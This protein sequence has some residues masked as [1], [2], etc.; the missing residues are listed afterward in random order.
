MDVNAFL[1]DVINSTN[2]TLSVVKI[3]LEFYDVLKTSSSLIKPRYYNMVEINRDVDKIVIGD[4][5]GDL[6][7][8]VS[9]LKRENLLKKLERNEAVLVFL[10]DYI[11][12]GLFQVETIAAV[13][14]LK[15]LAPGNVV[16]LRGN[17]EPS[18]I[19]VPYPHDFTEQLMNKYGNSWRYVY[20][21]FLEVF[22]K[23]P[24]IAYVPSQALL[25]H[26]GPPANVLYSKSF[27]EAFTLDKPMVDD[28][29]LEDILWS[30]PIEQ[31]IDYTESFRGAGKLFG[32][33]VTE[34][35][36][37]LANVDFIV[38]A[39]EPVEGGYRID[40]GG[41]VITIFSSKAPV[42]GIDRVAY[43]LLEPNTT[44]ENIIEFIKS[45]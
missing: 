10:G 15:I 45:I 40:H 24:L 18:P 2:D 32:F 12:R 13:L 20:S 22:Q 41:H 1:K 5:H 44:R 35:T 19:L 7:T 23:I 31:D 8:L 30:D 3:V 17:H 28:S 21:I 34:K 42:Y 37:K 11:D 36:L 16:V 29:V 33:K 14:M 6:E 27:E 26:G 25:L 43:L 39:H 9:I 4:L 38:R